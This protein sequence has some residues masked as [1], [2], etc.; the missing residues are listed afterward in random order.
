MNLKVSCRHGGWHGSRL[1]EL[2]K[3]ESM[4]KDIAYSS[5]SLCYQ[6]LQMSS[7]CRS[8]IILSA[9]RVQSVVRWR[10]KQWARAVPVTPHSRFTISYYSELECWWQQIEGRLTHAHSKFEQVLGG[11]VSISEL[12]SSS[13]SKWH[14]WFPDIYTN[15]ATCRSKYH[16]F[17]WKNP[18]T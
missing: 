8:Y 4:G 15:I 12:H 14:G 6:P 5:V 18:R 10:K 1:S 17:S 11:W 9:L 3:T 13:N 7:F 16:F 2:R